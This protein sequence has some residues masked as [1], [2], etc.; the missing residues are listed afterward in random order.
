[1]S[2]AVLFNKVFYMHIDT[3]LSSYHLSTV[4]PANSLSCYSASYV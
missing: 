2:M 3:D 1:M 4:T